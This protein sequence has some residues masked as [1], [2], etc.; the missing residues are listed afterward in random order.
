MYCDYLVLLFLGFAAKDSERGSDENTANHISNILKEVSKYCN[1]GSDHRPPF[2]PPPPVVV[3]PYDFDQHVYTGP[4]PI[5]DDEIQTN[6]YYPYTVDDYIEDHHIPSDGI[7]VEYGSANISPSRRMQ[8]LQ[9]QYGD[10][11]IV[12]GTNELV[13]VVNNNQ[14]AMVRIPEPVVMN[15]VTPDQLSVLYQKNQA[16]EVPSTDPSAPRLIAMTTRV[17]SSIL[18]AKKR[19]HNVIDH[20]VAGAE[21][22]FSGIHEAAGGIAE[23]I[24]GGAHGL[25]DFIV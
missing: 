3:S 4:D 24:G 17:L 10:L 19:F 20:G 16:F 2:L 11:P 8:I 12:S 21:N 23:L 1:D 7:P 18:K 9:N 14:V 5:F 15:L 13:T 6:E 25:L 22:V